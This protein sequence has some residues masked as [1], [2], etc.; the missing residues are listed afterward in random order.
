MARV[1]ALVLVALAA[2]GTFVG[3]QQS[4][5][6]K[7]ATNAVSVYATVLDQNGRLVP[8]LKAEDFEV[9]DNGKRQDLALFS[10]AIQPITIVV[11]L[12]R[13]G[14]MAGQFAFV[15]KAAGELVDHLL[16]ADR[17]RIGSFSDRI[18]I[19]PQGFTSDP[20]ELHRILRED[21]QPAG[22]T[23]LWNATA[24]ALNALSREPGRRVVLMFTD[25]RNNPERPGVVFSEIR[26]RVEREETMVYAIGLGSCAPSPEPLAAASSELRFQGRRAPAGG[27]TGR[28][29]PRPGGGVGRIPIPIG[30][31][32]AGRRLPPIMLPPMGGRIPGRTPLPYPRPEPVP[33]RPVP[34]SPAPGSPGSGS[35]DPGWTPP[36]TGGS[37]DPDLR[38]LADRAGGGYF[39]LHATDDLAATFTRIADELHHQYLLSFAPLTLDGK[40]HKIEVRVR[41]GD[42]AVRARRSYISQ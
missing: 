5:T 36:C 41:Q 12:D 19:D 40:V 23:P 6:F 3:A 30:M 2:G 8:D 7:S 14:S 26:D 11:M 21:L 9:Y 29:G 37:P 42:L 35:T 16:P 18:Q 17:A 31:G 22:P 4:P 32:G 39:E 1:T 33:P 15:T 38:V 13:S 28:A 34:G 25:G 10:N 27:A 20:E 24:V